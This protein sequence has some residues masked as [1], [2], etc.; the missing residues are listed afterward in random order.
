[1]SKKTI[2]RWTFC[3]SGLQQVKAQ[4]SP[5]AWWEVTTTCTVT[6]TETAPR[7]APWWCVRWAA[8]QFRPLTPDSVASALRHPSTIHNKHRVKAGLVWLSDFVESESASP[9]AWTTNLKPSIHFSLIRGSSRLSNTSFSLLTTF[10]EDPEVFPGHI[11]YIMS[12]LSCV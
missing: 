12:V 5:S 7:K 4:T 10:L 8:S 3:L 9:C 2:K 11:K 6:R 1:M